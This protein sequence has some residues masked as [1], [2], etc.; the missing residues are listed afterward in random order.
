MHARGG[1]A[2]NASEAPRIYGGWAAWMD[3]TWK[4][5]MS[6]KPVPTKI[7]IEPVLTCLFHHPRITTLHVGQHSLQGTWQWEGHSELVSMAGGSNPWFQC[8]CWANP[9]VLL[10]GTN[11]YGRQN[12]ETWEEIKPRNLTFSDRWGFPGGSVVRSLPANAGAT[13]SIH[14]P[15]RSHM[16]QSN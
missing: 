6:E 13:G 10:P 5:S 2:M 8:Y 9:P 16:L 1:D 11:V 7:L 4:M 15:G 12:V 14:N 3:K